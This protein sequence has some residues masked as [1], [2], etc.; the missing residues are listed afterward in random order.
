LDGFAEIL[1]ESSDE[2]VVERNGDVRAGG[3]A[4]GGAIALFS[5]GKQGELADEQNAPLD[6]LNGAVHHAVVIVKDSESDNFSAQPFD[7]FGRVGD[8]D[9]KQNEQAGLDRSFDVSTNRDVSSGD[10][11]DDCAHGGCVLFGISPT[12]G[13]IGLMNTREVTNKLQD[14]Q[15]KATKTARTVGEATDEYVHENAWSSIALAAV[16]GCIV[17]FLMGRSRD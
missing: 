4:V 16:V 8:F 11:L 3:A 10:S 12:K 13:Y 5:A 15:K 7:V 6:V 9:R 14:W 1:F 2:L 17:G